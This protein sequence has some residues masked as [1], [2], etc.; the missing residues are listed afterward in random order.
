MNKYGSIERRIVAP[1]VMYATIN[2]PAD[3]VTGDWT[4]NLT[5]FNSLL[6]ATLNPNAN[7]NLKAIGLYSNFA[8]GLVWKSGDPIPA[9][10]SVH[11]YNEGAALAAINI[12]QGSRSMT[13]TDTTGLIAGDVIKVAG[14]Y[15]QV[16]TV[17]NGTDITTIEP[18]L[19][20]IVNSAGKRLVLQG[21]G[22]T[23]WCYFNSFNEMVPFEA[24]VTP[25]TLAATAVTDIVISATIEA[26]FTSFMTKSVDVS[27]LGDVVNVDMVAEIEYTPA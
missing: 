5:L 16:D 23:G 13:M 4:T 26:P 14:G 7:L 3:I 18:A 10:V 19:I 22:I 27:Y 6:A 15:F 9:Y 21:S 12:A 8:D 24:I 11:A 2:P 20:G 17:V 25:L 1:R